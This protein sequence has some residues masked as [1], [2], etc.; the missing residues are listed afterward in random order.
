MSGNFSEANCL[1]FGGNFRGFIFWDTFQVSIGSQHPASDSGFTWIPTWGRFFLHPTFVT[2]HQVFSPQKN[3]QDINPP[4]IPP[5]NPS[6]TKKV[7]QQ[8]FAFRKE[9]DSFLA[10]DPQFFLAAKFSVKSRLP[11]ALF[12]HY[13]ASEVPTV[14]IPGCHCWVPG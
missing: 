11:V 2:S 10:L 13:L 9:L 14:Q 3:P 1:N 4:K 7:T 6:R 5:K 12:I 8:K